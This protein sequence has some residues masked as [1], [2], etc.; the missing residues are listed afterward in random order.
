M[1]IN[2]VSLFELLNA[3][4]VRFVLVGGL[5]VVLHG[6]DRLTADAD[7]I[8]DLSIQNA[9]STVTALVAAGYRPLAPVDP[10]LFADPQVREQW[11]IHKGMTVFSMWDSKNER[12]SVD[13]FVSS[14]IPFETLY[15]S[16]VLIELR[17]V[18]VRLASLVHLVAMK[19]I[20]GRDRDLADIR[21]IESRIAKDRE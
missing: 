19:R 10:L 8:V 11:R 18:S 16:S 17:G 14:P 9:K 3:A 1:P 20:A 21:L 12:P 4:H 7:I 6:F 5:A 13:I 15:A 2:F